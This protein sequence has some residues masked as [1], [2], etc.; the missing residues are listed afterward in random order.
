M[1]LRH[2]RYF[3]TV[4]ETCHFGRAAE[5]LHVAQP[6]L[7]HTIRQLEDE[8][9]VVLLARTTR[10]VRVTPAGEFFL[11][12]A[13]RV[14][15]GLDVGIRGVRRIGEGKLGL[16]RVGFTGTAAFSHLPHLARALAQRVPDVE[17]EIRADLLTAEQCERLRTGTLGIGV[18]RPPVTGD[19][20]DFR[21]IESEPLVLAV[22]ADH[23]LAV[24]PVVAMTDLRT[25]PLVTYDRR[26]SVVYEAVARS[27][28]EAGLTPHQLH[29]ASGTAVLLALVAGGLGVGVVPASAR[30]LPLAGVVFRDLVGAATV[31]LALAWHRETQSPLV[32]TVLDA[33][34]EVFPSVAPSTGGT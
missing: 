17:L 25:E 22:P 2:L 30:A 29:E 3:V 15:A 6:A 19:D 32:T 21:V 13:R 7:S 1:E 10:Q 34:E 20:I 9:G 27:C 11:A 31:E 23:R 33:L 14:L 8:L 26:N 16:L 24:E 5:Q 4:A 18:L 28:R 12:E